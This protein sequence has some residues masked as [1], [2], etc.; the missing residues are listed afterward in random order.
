[1]GLL[2]FAGLSAVLGLS[3]SDTAPSLSV[4]TYPESTDATEIAE[5]LELYEQ[6]RTKIAE[7]SVALDENP[8]KPLVN[9]FDWMEEQD[10]KMT[11]PSLSVHSAE[12]IVAQTSTFRSELEQ[13]VADAQARRVNA[14][15]SVSEGIVDA[16]GNGF[17]DIQWDAATARKTDSNAEEGCRTTGCVNGGSPLAVVF[18]PKPSS[19]HGTAE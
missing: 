17:T 7:L 15:G 3:D 4:Q 16:A 13:S 18:S 12:S 2:A 1:M 9:L 10:A 14:S 11:D 5:H 19:A 6:E 8:V